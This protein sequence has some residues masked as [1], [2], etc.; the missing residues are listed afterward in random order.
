MA[1][2]RKYL[3]SN[4]AIILVLFVAFVLR[5]WNLN[6]Q[7]LWLDEV[8]TMIESDP[9]TTWEYLYAYLKTIDVHPPLHYLMQ[10]VVF[11]VFGH[12][13]Y[14]ARL[15][16]VVAGTLGVAAIYFLGKEI[17]N[18]KLGIIVAVITAVNYYALYYS[19]EARNYI[20]LFLFATLSF[21]YL[22]RLIK[23]PTRK[24]SLLYAFLHQEKL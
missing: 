3:V 15:F 7:S 8:H 22:L 5:Y 10:K 21:L 1:D 17:L 24:N 16:S 20:F 6:Y 19:Q 23:R 14:V 18:K 9:D 4:G 2:I 12:T 13:A 11:I